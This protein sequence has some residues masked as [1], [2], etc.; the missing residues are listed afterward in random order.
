[1][2]KLFKFLLFLAVSFNIFSATVIF[3]AG[4]VLINKNKRKAMNIVGVGNLLKSCVKEPLLIFRIQKLFYEYLNL[5]PATTAANQLQISDLPAKDDNGVIMPPIMVDWL[6]GNISANQI[7]DELKYVTYREPHHKDVI[8]AVAKTLLPEY[9]SQIMN[10]EAKMFDFVAECKAAGHRVVILSNFDSLTFEKVKDSNLEFA[11]FDAFYL[12]GDLQLVKP[13]KRIFEK[14][15]EMEN[16]TADKCLFIDDCPNNI[17]RA[18]ELGFET[19]YCK[20][21]RDAI[22]E[23]R[24][25]LGM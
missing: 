12:S 19:V 25:K 4:G 24:S 5:I 8:L 14:L 22:K 18:K 23:A 10:I 1:M 13:Q 20:H 17:A 16:T 15:L 11:Y 6:L 3:D 9:L 7:L 2:K 21:I